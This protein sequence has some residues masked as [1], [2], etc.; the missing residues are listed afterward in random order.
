MSKTETTKKPRKPY[1]YKL[2]TMWLS[3]EEYMLLR[4]KAKA[5]GVAMSDIVRRSCGIEI[6]DR[7]ENKKRLKWKKKTK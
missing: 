1:P 7:N 5:D 4:L 6:I 3:E 2:F